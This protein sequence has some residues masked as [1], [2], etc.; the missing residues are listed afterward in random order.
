MH[1]TKEF[2]KSEYGQHI[3][4]TLQATAKGHLAGVADISAEHPDRYAAKFSAVKEVLELI[5][6]PLDDDIPPLG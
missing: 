3:V 4:S 6:Q 1:D 2:L 5:Y